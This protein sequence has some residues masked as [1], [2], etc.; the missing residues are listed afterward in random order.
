MRQRVRRQCCTRGR[1][2]P[3][4]PRQLGWGVHAQS[5]CSTLRLR[6]LSYAGAGLQPLR[7]RTD[8]LR[9]GLRCDGAPTVDTGRRPALPGQPGRALPSCRAYPALAHAPGGVG[10]VHADAG[11]DLHCAVRSAI[12]DASGFPIGGLRCCTGHPFIDTRRR[13]T[14]TGVTR[15]TMY[16]RH[17]QQRTHGGHA[18]SP[19]RRRP[20]AHH[21][22]A[23]ALPLVPKTLRR[24]RAAGLPAP[25]PACAQ[26][27]GA[28]GAQPWL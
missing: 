23:L 26:D 21:L 22:A 8:L 17:H 10:H 15:P 7:P 25:Q 14:C 2:R 1:F 12:G 19:G 18:G 3:A 4:H 9:C 16:D 27:Q 24:T 11:A 28:G 5:S 13:S 20:R 6:A